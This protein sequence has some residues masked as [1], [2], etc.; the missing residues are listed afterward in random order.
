MPGGLPIVA[1]QQTPCVEIEHQRPMILIAR[2][3][4]APALVEFAINDRH[5]RSSPCLPRS[6]AARADSDDSGGNRTE[7]R[8]NGRL[9]VRWSMD[10]GRFSAGPSSQKKTGRCAARS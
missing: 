5:D 8:A 6:I 4:P 1:H 2:A 3:R 9:V 7:K 10:F